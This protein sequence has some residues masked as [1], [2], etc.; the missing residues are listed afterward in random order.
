MGYIWR[1]RHLRCRTQWAI[2][3][4]SWKAIAEPT[5]WSLRRSEL[6]LPGRQQRLVNSVVW[7]QRWSHRPRWLDR[8]Y[9]YL[10]FSI[11]QNNNGL[12]LTSA[13]IPPQTSRQFESYHHPLSRKEG[14]A[15]SVINNFVD[16]SN[17]VAFLSVPWKDDYEEVLAHIWSL[18]LC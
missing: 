5:L 11:R 4:L 14:I 10:H 2:H 3:R 9:A 13:N 16:K 8:T 17:P 15:F 18:V 1:C 7:F 6:W 12:V